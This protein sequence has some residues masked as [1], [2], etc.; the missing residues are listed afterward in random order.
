MR[1]PGRRKLGGQCRRHQHD[2]H[3]QRTEPPEDSAKERVHEGVVSMGLVNHQD[4]AGEPEQA[5]DVVADRQ[6]TEQDLVDRADRDGSEQA[7]LAASQP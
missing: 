5:E 6:D 4:F 7:A 2:R 1:R 3:T